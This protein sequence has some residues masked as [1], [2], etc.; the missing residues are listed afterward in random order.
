MNLEHFHENSFSTLFVSKY[1]LN[2]GNSRSFLHL[3]YQL[4]TASKLAFCSINNDAISFLPNAQATIK[5]LFPLK[6]K[7]IIS[8]EYEITLYRLLL[9][10]HCARS[11]VMP[12]LFRPLYK[13]TSQIHKP[14][15][16]RS[17][18]SK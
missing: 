16:R 18:H 7:S 4:V 3:S 9:S 1:T 2:S 6:I 15:S 12:L 8:C 5:A 13:P 11:I 14:S 10:W 17:S